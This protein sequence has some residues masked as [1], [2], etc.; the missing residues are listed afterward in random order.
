M[1]AVFALFLCCV[2]IASRASFL[3]DAVEMVE[4]S[5][6]D[7]TCYSVY[8]GYYFPGYEPPFSFI[9]KIFHGF[10]SKSTLSKM[11]RFDGNTAQYLFTPTDPKGHLCGTS[12]N[13]LWGTTRCG[14]L[15]LVHQDSDR[16]VWRRAQSCL[17]YKGDYVT[18]VKPNCT[19]ANRIELAAYTYD[20]GVVPY[21]HIGTLLKQFKAT[22]EIGVWYKYTL[23]ITDTQTNFILADANGNEIERQFTLHRNCSSQNKGNLLS[24][25]FGGQCAAPQTVT[26]CYKDI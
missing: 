18:G 17:N 19:E 11:I 14:Y 3:E 21:Q 7:G 25:Y 24:F 22:V 13:K 6:N 10:N 20:N 15:D 2:V 4:S 16:F 23:E 9:P 1:K 26:A 5:S 12:W 8:S